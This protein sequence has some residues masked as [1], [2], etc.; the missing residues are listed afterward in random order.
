MKRQLLF[1]LILTIQFGAFAS[2]SLKITFS[3]TE[4]YVVK[5]GGSKYFVDNQYLQLDYLTE[6]LYSVKFSVRQG[7]NTFLVHQTD[8]YL[9][10]YT[11]TIGIFEN[12]VLKIKSVNQVGN[13]ASGNGWN[14][15]NYFTDA[16]FGEVMAAVSEESF[17]DQKGQKMVSLIK[18]GMISSNQARQLLELFS[19]DSERYEAAIAIVPYVHD[20]KNLYKLADVFSFKSS[21]D[22]FL[23][24]IDKLTVSG[25]SNNTFNNSNGNYMS[26]SGFNQLLKNVEDESFDSKKLDLIITSVKYTKITTRQAIELLETFSFDSYRLEAANEMIPYIWDPE[27]YWQAGETFEFKS[28]E[29]SFL[30]HIK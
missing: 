12:N 18:Q 27:N 9:Q 2:A 5:I 3:G 16:E 22:D 20:P 29:D 13:S 11:E 23:A 30:E 4:A 1:L 7:M 17:D 6:G 28:N 8:I 14:A 25:T 19:F 10:D 24:H 21:R 15:D 26:V